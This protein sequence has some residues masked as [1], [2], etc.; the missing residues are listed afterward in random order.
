MT[1]S[2]VATGSTTSVKSSSQ[3]L[4]ANFDNFLKLLTTQLQN[5]DPLAPM[6]ANAFT[7][8]QHSCQEGEERIIG[9]PRIDAAGARQASGGDD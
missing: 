1:V 9:W 6:D 2:A 3:S 8:R 7:S 4:A 5:Q